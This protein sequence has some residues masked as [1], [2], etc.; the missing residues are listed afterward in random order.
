MSFAKNN[1][2]LLQRSLAPRRLQFVIRDL[3]IEQIE[4][5]LDHFARFIRRGRAH[6]H[7]ILNADRAPDECQARDG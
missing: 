2:E 3:A 6:G 7:H 5:K 4:G 1:W